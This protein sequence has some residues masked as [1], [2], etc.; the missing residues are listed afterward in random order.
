MSWYMVRIFLQILIDR[1]EYGM[2]LESGSSWTH[3]SYSYMTH[4]SGV[5]SYDLNYCDIFT[6][7]RLF[8][9]TTISSRNRV[10]RNM[11]LKSEPTSSQRDIP[12]YSTNN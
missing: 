3:Y 4:F 8:Q 7:Q 11:L 1:V 9:N 5:L 10:E 2:V 6:F 12:L